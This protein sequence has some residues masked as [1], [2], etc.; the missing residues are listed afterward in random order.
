M[1]L[2]QDDDNQLIGNYLFTFGDQLKFR[3]QIAKIS[4]LGLDPSTKTFEEALKRDVQD[5]STMGV[6]NKSISVAEINKQLV[7]VRAAAK[8]EKK[9]LIIGKEFNMHQHFATLIEN[10]KN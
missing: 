7:A 10:L 9:D 5:R 6:A 4:A 8:I 2:P 3:K 1:L